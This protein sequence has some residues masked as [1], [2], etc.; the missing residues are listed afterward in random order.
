[1]VSFIFFSSKAK[2]YVKGQTSLVVFVRKYWEAD[3][4]LNKHFGDE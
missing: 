3:V 1:M 2:T 4:R